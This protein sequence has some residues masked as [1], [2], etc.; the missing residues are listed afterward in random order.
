[1]TVLSQQD[2]ARPVSSN[3]P[4]PTGNPALDAVLSGL[5]RLA[6]ALPHALAVPVMVAHQALCTLTEHR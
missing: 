4:A 5:E 3:W 6:A 1:M 2:I